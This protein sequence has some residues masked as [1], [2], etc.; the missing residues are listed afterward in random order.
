MKALP[1]PAAKQI[2]TID[3]DTIK[4]D[5]VASVDLMERASEVFSIWFEK[6]FPDREHSI[7][8]FCGPG[9][10]GGDGL[11]VSR[12]LLKNGFK[13][14]VVFWGN[15]AKCS[16]DCRI[17]FDRLKSK[18]D[19]KVFVTDKIENIP[20]IPEN[21]IVIDALLGSGLDRPLEGELEKL[22]LKLNSV[23]ATRVSIDIPTGLFSDK[24]TTGTSFAADEVL[25]FEF[26]KPAFLMPENEG[27]IS[28]WDFKSIGLKVS[29]EMAK[30]LNNYWLSTICIQSLLKKTNRFSHKGTHGT[31][32]I[33]AG[34]KGFCGAAVLA[35]KSCLRAGCG[36]LYTHLP[37]SCLDIVQKSIP[38][39]ICT[40]NAGLEYLESDIF[41]PEKTKA[42]GIGPGIGTRYPTARIVEKIIKNA[43]VPIVIDADALNIIATNDFLSSVP[44]NAILTPHPGEF[45][46][47]FGES[48]ND[49]EELEL[50]RKKSV[51]HGVF[52]V[53]KGAFTRISTPDGKVFFNSSGNPGLAKAGSGDVLTGIITALLARSYSPFEAAAIGVHLH[54]LAAELA[55]QHESVESL[56]ATDVINH[57]GKAFKEIRSE[58]RADEEFA[59]MIEPPIEFLQK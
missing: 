48:T 36:L 55:I 44:K 5:Y 24:T 45:R 1:I 42:I 50:Q 29:E 40:T 28:N 14:T 9:N 59:D 16:K 37:V 23:N 46:R 31:A 54:G 21:S 35:A 26:P 13:V 51:E 10:N 47:L 12:I 33:I 11:A 8:I 4:Q 7:F 22:V 53:F 43:K 38:E 39:A 49:F 20:S 27:K 57:I 56:L 17:N 52:I 3:S 34:Q 30:Q 25:S 41:T 15:P 6:K 58:K 32:F 19:A 2:I 18:D